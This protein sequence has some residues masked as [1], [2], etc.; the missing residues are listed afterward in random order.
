[1][2]NF[3][4]T[5][6]RLAD[7]SKEMKL[8]YTCFLAFVVAGLLT[9][10]A[11]Q[12]ARIGPTYERI[13]AH[14]RGGEVGEE[15][16]FPKTFGELIELTHFH[17]F[18]MGIIFLVLAHLSIAT[19]MRRFMK[20]FLIFT[21][22]FSTLGNLASPWLIRYLLPIFALLQLLS[23]VGI[24]VGYGGMIAISF[25]EMWLRAYRSSRSD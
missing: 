6:F 13:V 3:T 1:L 9:I 4:N 21:A 19:S 16:A 18:V 15:M 11:Y 2:R 10:G 23:W 17:T 22:F 7:A 8:I 14:Y 24:W 20:F 12:V 25:H 5:G